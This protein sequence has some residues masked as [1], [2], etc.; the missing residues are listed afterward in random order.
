MEKLKYEIKVHA[1]PERVWETLIS[2]ES[3]ATWSEPFSPDS[4]FSGEWGEGSKIRFTAHGKGGTVAE[5]RKFEPYK[6]IDA[7]HVATIDKNGNEETTGPMTEHWI[8]T[9]ETYHLEKLK[10]ETK[11]TVEME[12][13]PDFKPMFENSWPEALKKVRELS[14]KRL[15]E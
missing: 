2:E 5:I 8:G 10:D 3:F 7:V 1:D 9:R 12:T 14:E 15:S 4:Q 13:H 11:L 6:L